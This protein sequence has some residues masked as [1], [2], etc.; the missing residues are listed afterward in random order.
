MF[1]FSHFQCSM[2]YSASH[3]SIEPAVAG[4]VNLLVEE[5]VVQ[6]SDDRTALSCG[7]LE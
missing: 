1:V 2:P 5:T 3:L 6:R 4:M 7:E